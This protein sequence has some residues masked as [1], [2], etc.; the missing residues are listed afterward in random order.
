MMQNLLTVCFLSRLI[1]AG[2][3]LS[4]EVCE[5]VGDNC[6]GSFH[7]CPPG[8]DTCGIIQEE[9]TTRNTAGDELYCFEMSETA[10]LGQMS[11]TSA[12]K[13]CTNS[14]TCSEKLHSSGSFAG[15]SV[16]TTSSCTLAS[17]RASFVPEC[18]EFFFQAF[19]GILLGKLFS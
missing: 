8:F 13:G 6:M 17:G 10:G 4:C 7:T 15:T 19:T 5:D 11:V 1:A 14:A 18:T 2:A 9:T 12:M 3:S 16:I